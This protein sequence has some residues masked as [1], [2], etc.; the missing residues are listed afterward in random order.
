MSELAAERCAAAKAIR[1][2]GARPVMFEEFGAA[3][4]IL[5]RRTLQSLNHQTFTSVYWGGATESR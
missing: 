5:N 2:V 1:T 4:Q 3:T